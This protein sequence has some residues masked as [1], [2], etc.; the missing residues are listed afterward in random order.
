MCV[1]YVNN[2]QSSLLIPYKAGTCI[3]YTKNCQMDREERLRR[4]RERDRARGKQ[5]KKEARMA[6]RREI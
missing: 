2:Y 5:Q 3:H 4:R 1:H 6:R